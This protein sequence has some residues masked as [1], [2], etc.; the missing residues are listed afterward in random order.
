MLFLTPRKPHFHI[1]QKYLCIHV[2][3]LFPEYIYEGFWRVSAK[4]KNKTGLSERLRK[5]FIFTNSSLLLNY[6][7]SV[8]LLRTPCFTLVP[9]RVKSRL[10]SYHL[11]YICAIQVRRVLA[12]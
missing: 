4:C 7:T 2:L 1:G 3:F 6:R 8:S 10:L 12:V 11:I 9:L 5:T